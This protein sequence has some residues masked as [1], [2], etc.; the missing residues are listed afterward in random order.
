VTIALYGKHK[1]SNSMSVSL[2]MSL[3]MSVSISVSVGVSVLCLFPCSVSGNESVSIKYGA[4][5]IFVWRGNYS[6]NF[7]GPYE[8]AQ[9]LKGPLTW[10]GMDKISWKSWRL[11]LKERPIGWYHFQPNK[12]RWTVPLSSRFEIKRANERSTTSRRGGKLWI[13]SRR[14]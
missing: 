8:V 10:E 5:N 12:S 9:K 4:T 14:K 3:S 1:C 11:F 13:S 2:S 6:V 7:Q